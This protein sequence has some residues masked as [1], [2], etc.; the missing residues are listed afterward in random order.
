[1][2]MELRE[3]DLGQL[4]A[5]ILEV[6]TEQF[7]RLFL[8][9]LVVG[10]PLLVTQLV[11]KPGSGLEDLRLD[12]P[13]EELLPIVATFYGELG[14]LA[15][16]TAITYPI[17]QATAALLVRQLV[18]GERPD[19]LACL[20]GALRLFP[21]CLL[22]SVTLG[23]ITTLGSLCCIAPG[24]IFWT[25]FMVVIPVLALEGGP[26][27]A[28]FGRSRA[29]VGGIN[30]AR[31]G[32]F[33]EALAVYLL[34][35]FAPAMVMTPLVMGLSLVPSPAAQA[36][37]GHFAMITFGVIPLT[38]PSVLYYH[39]RVVREAHDVDRLADL[40]DAIG[41]AAPAPPKA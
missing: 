25:W 23:V 33:W 27:S 41:A 20:R 6:A 13:P 24:V 35:A 17:E 38:A 9:Q 19:L 34:A 39:L 16:L 12:T 18:D 8:L 11:L 31:G 36:I 10:L 40:V 29:L 3:R 21:R 1:M 15:L 14:L 32:R 26:W 5:H 7:G 2:S 37:I 28:A 30:P 22:L 4:L